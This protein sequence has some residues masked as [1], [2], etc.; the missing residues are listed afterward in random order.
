[1]GGGVKRRG[2]KPFPYFYTIKLR[3][4]KFHVTC[5]PLGAEN[6]QEIERGQKRESR[7]ISPITG[8][9][10]A[11]CC[12]DKVNEG[13]WNRKNQIRSENEKGVRAKGKKGEA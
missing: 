8:P 7:I 13:R 4:K 5:Q 3:D 9:G 10:K 6:R 1:V 11:T 2:G 12:W